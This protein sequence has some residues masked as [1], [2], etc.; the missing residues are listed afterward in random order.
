MTDADLESLTVQDLRELRG[1]VDD[2]IRAQIAR[3]R[4]TTTMVTASSS[5]A[6]APSVIDLE[7]ERDA[8]QARRR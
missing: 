7:R 4:P 3:S 5:G 1:R 8:W 2:A 6:P